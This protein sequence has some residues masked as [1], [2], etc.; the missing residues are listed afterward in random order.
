VEVIRFRFTPARGHFYGPPKSADPHTPDGGG[1]FAPVDPARAFL[2]EN[3]GWQGARADTTAPDAPADT[4]DGADVN[5]TVNPSLGVV[6]DTCE[7]RIEVTL[8]FGSPKTSLTAAANVFV[9]P[10]DFAPDRRPFLSLADELNDREADSAARTALMSAPDRDAW[11]QDLFERIYETV[12]LFNL[13]LQRRAKASR[14]T[15]DQLAPAPIAKDKT[16][17]PTRAMGGQDALRN[18]SFPLSA[19]SQDIRLPLTDHARDRHHELS[20]LEGLRNFV[21]RNP[22]RLA[23][24]I[25]ASFEAARGESAS[26]IGTTTMRMPPFMRNSN[27]GPLTLATWQYDLL[28]A[29]VKE[30]ESQPPPAAPI[31][32]LARRAARPL[33][34]GAT[35]RRQ[36]VLERIARVRQ[37]TSS[38]GRS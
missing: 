31:D 26:G 36:L 32:A 14:L 37:R 16:R 34:E 1:S 13:D 3:A 15:G 24:L 5:P 38:G 19:V 2:N 8:R 6:D 20:T 25:R 27:A 12:S 17:E 23:N 30:T 28:M 29:W 22:G 4:Y 35:Q 21:V 9:A 10:P 18:S 11:V 7:A 33:S